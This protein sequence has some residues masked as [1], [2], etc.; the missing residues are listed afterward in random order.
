MGRPFDPARAT[1]A[2]LQKLEARQKTQAEARAVSEGVAETVTLSRARGSAMVQADGGAR[3]G[4]YQRQSGLGWLTRKGRLT[5]LQAAA[6]E[7]YGAAFRRAGEAPGIKSTL[8]VQ[9]GAGV[10][11]GPSLALILRLGEG[12]R[13]AAA[14]LVD[15]RRRLLGQGDLI[16]AC[17]LVCGEELTPREACGGDSREAARV[18]AV[19][20]VALD[21][22]AQTP[23]A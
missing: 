17:D 4:P 7:R 18:E 11:A 21:I 22:L 9:P 16:A 12:R 10:A 13:Q 23:R 2:R 14:Q 20:K 19:L 8:D 1:R 5:P 15:F 6:G 3:S